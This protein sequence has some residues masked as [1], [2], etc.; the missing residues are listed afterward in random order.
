[1]SIRE[2]AIQVLRSSGQPLTA[3]QIT[4]PEKIERLRSGDG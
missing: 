4:D 2:A 1:M 3:Q